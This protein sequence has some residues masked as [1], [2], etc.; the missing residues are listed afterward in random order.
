MIAKRNDPIL[1]NDGT[2]IIAR[3]AK[4][5]N[6]MG[7]YM[8]IARMRRMHLAYADY[9]AAL[10]SE[11]SQIETASI[12]PVLTG[13]V[14]VFRLSCATPITDENWHEWFGPSLFSREIDPEVGPGQIIAAID[15]IKADGRLNAICQQGGF[16]INDD[17]DSYRAHLVERIERNRL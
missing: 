13:P 7:D 10:S 12:W 3:F 11:D 14:R 1:S 2:T 6:L 17:L 8:K 15:A 16:R 4:D 9:D 5:S